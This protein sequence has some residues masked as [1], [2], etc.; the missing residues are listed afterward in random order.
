[1]ADVKISAMTDLAPPTSADILPI[2]RAGANGRW[3]LSDLETYLNTYLFDR[4]NTYADL[5]AATGSGVIVQV[6][7]TTGIIGFRNLAGMYYDAAPS[8]WTYLGLYGR[9][10]AEIA[11][12]P[13]GTISSTDVQAAIN[14]LDGDVQAHI[15]SGGYNHAD[16]TTSVAGFMTAADKTKLDAIS[17]TN[18]GDQ[19]SI[20]GITGT[21]A[22]FDTAV[23]DGN[24]L[25]VGDITQYTDE[26]AQDA[27]GAMAGASLIY[28][29][30]TPLLARAALTGDITAA[31]DS[32]ATTLA[33]TAVSPGSY[34]SA[35]I[36]VDAKG[37]I[38]AAASGVAALRYSATIGD[39]STTAIVV[40]HNLGTKD[41]VA[42]VRAVATDLHIICD[43]TST[44]TTTATFT[45]AS[46]PATN[47][48]RVTI[49]G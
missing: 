35:D 10:A 20:V 41:I 26:A 28:V 27:V 47:A 16:A 21:K 32:N 36:T 3:S 23:T 8:T 13:A 19:T 45:F 38:T 9:S 1:M 30:G 39:G 40:T 6:M 33:N 5:P 15:G 31:Q 25:Y 34:T 43:I 24:I 18:T 37:R 48:Y 17:G 49:L 12:V 4:Y 22:Q 2:V 46:A 14:E 42:S 7:T 29:D 11:N 44:S